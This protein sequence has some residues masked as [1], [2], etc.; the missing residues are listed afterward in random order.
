MIDNR[1][2][3]SKK[4]PDLPSAMLRLAMEDLAKVEAD[5][6]Y[7]VQMSDWH[8]RYPREDDGRLVCHVCLAGSVMAKTLELPIDIADDTVWFSVENTFEDWRKLTMLDFLR[9]GLIEDAL[10]WVHKELPVGVPSRI[11]VTEYTNNPVQFK[12]DMEDIAT[13]LEANGL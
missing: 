11:E 10:D 7:T 1:I 12:M 13:V 6:L 3:K 4:L 9:S 2:P 8:S 5:P